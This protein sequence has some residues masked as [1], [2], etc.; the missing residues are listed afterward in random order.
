MATVM[1]PAWFTECISASGSGCVG[2]SLRGVVRAAGLRMVGG[3]S[4]FERC[5]TVS[6]GG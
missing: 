5:G 4:R 6:R 3:G 2:R 1:C